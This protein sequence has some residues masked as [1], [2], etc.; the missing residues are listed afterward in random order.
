MLPFMKPRGP[1]LRSAH[2]S[3]GWGHDAFLLLLL[4]QHNLYPLGFV[5]PFLRSCR[6]SP[7]FTLEEADSKAGRNLAQCAGMGAG[8]GGRPPD[9]NVVVTDLGLG[10]CGRG[11][12]ALMGKGALDS[13]IEHEH[14]P[15]P[16][17]SVALCDYCCLGDAAWSTAWWRMAKSVFQ[18]WWL[19]W[20]ICLM[21]RGSSF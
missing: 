17:S 14:K 16:L 13:P 11:R 7:H 12:N 18:C 15:N 3:T 1:V 4:P 5:S 20:F 19:L 9:L 21:T 8:G 6:Y 10:P 2:L